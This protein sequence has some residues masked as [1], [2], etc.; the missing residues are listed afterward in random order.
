[1]AIEFYKPEAAK[2]SRGVLAGSAGML[3]FYGAISLY[4]YLASPFWATPLPGVGEVLGEEFPFSPRTCLT[5]VIMVVSAIGIYVGVNHQKSVDFLVE[6]E[7]EMKK[8]TWP[9]PSEVKSSSQIVLLTTVVL[10]A[11]ICLVDFT[12]IYIKGINWGGLFGG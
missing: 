2:T 12:L 8:V 1:M 9:S 7:A 5:L 3:L 4:D 6:T 11:Y 10:A